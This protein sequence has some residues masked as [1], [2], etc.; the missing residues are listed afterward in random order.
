MNRDSLKILYVGGLFKGSTGLERKEAFEKLGHCIIPF[1]TD[2]YVRYG[3]RIAISLTHRLNWGPALWSLNQEL[4]KFARDYEY[5]LVWV[6]KGIWIY[7]NTLEAIGKKDKAILVHYT[8]DPAIVFHRTRHFIKSIPIYDV[9]ITSKRWE[10]DKYRQYGAKRVIFMPQAV[11]LNLF[12]PYDVSGEEYDKLRSDVCFVGHCES[13]YCKQ[14]KAVFET[15]VNIAVWGLWHRHFWFHPWLKKIVRSKDIWHQ[16]Y[17]EALCCTK[18]GLGLLSKLVPETATTRTFEI[19]ACGTFVLA[20]R[21]DEHLEYFEEGR[22]AEFFGSTEE[23]VDKVK[24]YLAHDEQRKKI[25][26]AGRERCLKSGY[27]N[28]SRMQQ[29]LKII[30]ED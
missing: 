13:H 4:I 11:N 26:A 3:N 20:E 25:A 7:P 27:D 21:T 10:V 12:K 14:V 6:S 29:C 19:P 22:E 30:F 28:K 8:P 15:G 18:I 23:L 2:P 1:D 24:Y 17:A 9:L 5:D 16:N